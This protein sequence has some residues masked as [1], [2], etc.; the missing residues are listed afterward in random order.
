[1]GKYIMLSQQLRGGDVITEMGL[2]MTERPSREVTVSGVEA[3]ELFYRGAPAQV[4]F[5]SGVDTV[6]GKPVRWADNG[7]RR[8]LVERPTVSAVPSLETVDA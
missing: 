8:W 2:V 4:L 1:M 7:W 3:G 6:N 5:V